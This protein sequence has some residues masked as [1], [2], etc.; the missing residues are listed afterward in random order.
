MA[1]DC[2][3]CG[4]AAGE[5]PVCSRCGVVFAKLRAPQEPAPPVSYRYDD[6]EPERP[7]STLAVV[8]YVLIGATLVVGGLA[9][10]KPSK[11]PAPRASAAADVELASVTRPPSAQ[12][13][14]T[15][16]DEPPPLVAALPSELPPERVD[17][18]SAADAELYDS[19]VEKVNR[20]RPL[21]ALD[22]ESAAE[23][24]A[25]YPHERRMEQLLMEML[26]RA[27][28]QRQRARNIPEA[29]SLLKRASRLPSADS[30][31][32]VALLSLIASTMDWSQLESQAQEFTEAAPREAES[33]YYLGYAQFRQ[34]RN[35]EAIQSLK[36]C[37]E[38]QEHA[39]A[40][41]LLVRLERNKAD[42]KG[43]RDQQLSHFHVRY[44]GD[45]HDEVGREILKA[46]EKHYYTLVRALDH[47]P[48]TVVP[49][50]LFSSQKYFDAAGAPAWSGG[51]FDLMDGRI[52]IPIGGLDRNLTPDMDNTLIHELTHAFVND[53]TRGIAPRHVHE[54]V[55]QYMEGHRVATRFTKEQLTFLADGRAGGVGGFY[56]ESLSF[57]EYL[58]EQRGPGGVNDLLKAMGETGDVESAF[59]QVYGKGH[60]ATQ[61]A[62]RARLKQ[63][64]GTY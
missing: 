56:A 10:L 28:N 33:W 34:D 50:I 46:L 27:A 58:V 6:E 42:E 30:R 25:K 16:A 11:K 18:L 38:V 51:A 59:R 31:S 44:D 20:D 8:S 24:M 55:A 22:I 2:P 40:R 13:A 1:M 60:G 62:W 23:L 45:E 64:Y 61:Q 7:A 48:Q 54:G 37:L 43:M 3:R 26:L 35:R 47:E 17:G 4:F 52:R 39:Q 41:E 9:W 15:G 49:V 14:S 32:R 63:V 57:V 21:S 19:L 36:G 29:M 5:E 12:P 53:K